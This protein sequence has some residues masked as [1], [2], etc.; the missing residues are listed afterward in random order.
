MGSPI[1]AF[2]NLRWQLELQPNVIEDEDAP[3]KALIFLNLKALSPKIESVRLQILYTFFDMEVQFDRSLSCDHLYA[4]SWED[5]QG[6]F[7]RAKILEADEYYIQIDFELLAVY[8]QDGEDLTKYYLKQDKEPQPEQEEK[9]EIM[10]EKEE[11]SNDGK[12]KQ[13]DALMQQ[14]QKMAA[15]IENIQ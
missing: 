3:S 2:F 9:V 10:E 8:N 5:D 12:N 15:Q 1:F 14:M 11:K 6:V 7:A 13:M 4:N